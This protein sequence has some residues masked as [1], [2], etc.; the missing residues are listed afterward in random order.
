[1]KIIYD[2]FLIEKIYIKKL[3]LY[4]EFFDDIF[5]DIYII[6]LSIIIIYFILLLYLLLFYIALFII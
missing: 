5:Q 6:H 4:W 1:M 2:F 3:L